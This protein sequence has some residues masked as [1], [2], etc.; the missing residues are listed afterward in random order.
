[1]SV[2][3]ALAKLCACTCGGAI[4][5]GGAVHV[6]ENPP[7]RASFVK[8]ARM[9][10]QAPRRYARVKAVKR[11]R[12]VR[13][14]CVVR[15]PGTTTTTRTIT[16]PGGGMPMPLPPLPPM[17][18]SSGGGVTVI[19]GSGGFGGGFF[20]GGFFGGSSGNAIF[21]ASTSTSTGG[22]STGG[23]STS[24][25]GGSTS[26]SGGSTST[27]SGGSSTS[28]STGGHDVPAPPMLVLF[29]LAAAALVGRRKLAMAK[30]A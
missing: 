24:T 23:S 16:Y 6:A 22:S 26:T 25:S 13:T 29:G 8:Q 2:R 20:S 15:T 9:I 19:G 18:G 4:I 28:S 5:G 12:R 17:A 11:H 27:S 10:K 7:Q 3:M 21:T 30:A 1:M 14:A